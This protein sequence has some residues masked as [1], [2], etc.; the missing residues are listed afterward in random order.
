MP[1]P[2]L[3]E[4]DHVTKTFPNVTALADVSLAV[5]PGAIHVLLGEDGAGKT[6]VMRIAGG[7]HPIG[8]YS[9][10]VRFDGRP[11]AFRSPADAIKAGIGIVLR[12]SAVFDQLS[13]AE[14]VMLSSWQRGGRR[15][16]NP[17]ATRDEAQALLDHWDIKLEAGAK[18]AGLTPLQQRLV[19]I[20]RALSSQP[21]LVAMDEPFFGLT[22]AHGVSSII[23]ITRRLVQ[24]GITCLC[25]VRRVND[26]LQIGDRVTILRDGTV[27]GTWERSDFDEP[28]MT[29]AMI[30]QRPGDIRHFDDEEGAQGGIF[31][32]FQ[33]WF[34]AG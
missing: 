18:G 1:A 2:Y 4:F 19:M 5:M 3:L 14:N 7:A 12:R 20:A 26:A 27:A 21:R 25:L 9:G 29:R 13:V 22:D 17:R 6:T 24:E 31:A 33:R 11:I 32:A 28:A 30:S 34:R 16:V 15:L 8:S 23:Y 10:E